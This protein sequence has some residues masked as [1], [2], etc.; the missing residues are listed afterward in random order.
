MLT[1]HSCVD[2]S[3]RVHLLSD[4]QPPKC[5][6]CRLSSSSTDT[7][8][9]TCIHCQNLIPVH[10]T[11]S[12]CRSCQLY[13]TLYVPCV[14][15]RN[16]FLARPRVTH[17]FNCR[18]RRST[19]VLPPV[20]FGSVYSNSFNPSANSFQQSNTSQRKRQRLG[21]SSSRTTSARKEASSKDSCLIQHALELLTNEYDARAEASRVFPTP[22]TDFQIRCAISRF[23]S[24][25]A[26]A[27]L[28]KTYSLCGRFVCNNEIRQLL[29]NNYLLRPLQGGLDLCGWS[30]GRWSIYSLCYTTLLRGSTP[31]F[32]IKN[33]INVTLCQH[34]PSALEDLILTEEYLIAKSHSVGV[35]LKL[36][37]GGRS[38][39]ANYHTIRGYFIIIPQNPKPLLQIL[40]SLELQFTELIKVFWMGHLPS[41]DADLR[42]FLTICKSRVLAVLQYLI[43]YNKLYQD[44]TICYSTIEIWP[45]DFIPSV[46]QQNIIYPDRNDHNKRAGYTNDLQTDNCENDWQ[47]ADGGQVDSLGDSIPVTASVTVDLNGDRYNPDLHLLN[48]IQ[49][50]NDQLSCEM[51]PQFIATDLMNQKAPSTRPFRHLPEIEY[52][53]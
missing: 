22:I 30:D 3:R 46:L 36:R 32:S 29:A 48:T 37:S 7:D 44:I 53:I 23:E 4:I 27:T 10:S 6:A 2:C 14:D 24:I 8:A 43:H 47:A 28:D 25:F 34:Y 33:K 51:R 9:R 45:D 49:S 20:D 21:S 13:P 5:P 26:V 38:S 39:P 31:K 18:S 16:N 52:G 42:S 11:S 15:C 35:I 50:F 41:S 40:P 1:L 17:C 19:V 12:L